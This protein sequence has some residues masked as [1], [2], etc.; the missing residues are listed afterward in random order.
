MARKTNNLGAKKPRKFSGKSRVRGG[1]A[2]PSKP[3]N[4]VKSKGM[5]KGSRG[6]G[7]G[8]EGYMTP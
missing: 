6:S 8:H 3:G 2:G 1:K 7:M 4:S 5:P